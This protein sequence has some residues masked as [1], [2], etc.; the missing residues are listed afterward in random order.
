MSDKKVEKRGGARPG[1][2]RPK[3][4]G[5]KTK[6]CVSVNEEN[7]QASLSKWKKEQSQKA[8]PSWLVDWL[9]AGYLEAKG[10]LQ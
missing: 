1:S 5:K 2:G 4:S 8:K 6:I 7:W 9:I 3:G 10:S